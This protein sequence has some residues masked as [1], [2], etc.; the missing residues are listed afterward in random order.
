MNMFLFTFN[1]NGTEE[2]VRNWLI[3]T[4]ANPKRGPT[5][6]Q[7]IEAYQTENLT[8][9]ELLEEISCQTGRT[10]NPQEA[11]VLKE[12]VLKELQTT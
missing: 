2:K 7:L 5:V 10:F 12:M 4:R 3:K 8:F 9:N 11:G 1:G 6:N